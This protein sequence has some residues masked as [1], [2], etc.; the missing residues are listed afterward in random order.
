MTDS[1]IEITIKGFKYYE[2]GLFTKKHSDFYFKVAHADF[3]NR[4]KE[5]ANDDIIDEAFKM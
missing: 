5:Y 1:Y 2:E 3:L 4:T